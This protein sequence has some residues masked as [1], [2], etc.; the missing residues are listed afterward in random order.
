MQLSFAIKNIPLFVRFQRSCYAAF[1]VPMNLSTDVNMA[2]IPIFPSMN[3][4]GEKTK[5]IHKL[6]RTQ[7]R[8]F[9]KKCTQNLKIGVK[10]TSFY[11]VTTFYYLD[12]TVLYFRKCVNFVS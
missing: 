9:S 10:I 2:D 7:F 8:V 3:K 5:D 1:I 4:G 6:L 11:D 12:K